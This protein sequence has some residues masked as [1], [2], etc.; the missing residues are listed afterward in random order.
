[1]ILEFS[2]E[3]YLSFKDKV[4]FSM[5]PDG[6]KKL[7]EN[8]VTLDNEKILK[9]AAVY[10]P[11]ASG[12]TNLFSMLSQIT[13]MLRQSNYVDINAPLP[14]VPFKFDNKIKNNPSSFEIKFIKNGIKYIYGFSADKKNIYEEY[15][16][17]YPNNKVA[18]IFDRTDI[19]TY[20]F[21][22]KSQTTLKEIQK[23]TPH[24]KFF[25]ATATNWNYQE[26]KPAYDFLTVDMGVCFSLTEL[27]FGA[28]K[29]YKNDKNERL[30]KFA[31]NFLNKADFNISDYQVNEVEIPKEIL[32]SV[33]LPESAKENPKAFQVS[34]SHKV[35]N[36]E[37]SLDIEEESIGTQ[38][39]FFLIP[40]ISDAIN[41]QKVLIIDE[42]DRSLH[43]LLV[44]YIVELFNNQS[45]ATPSQLIFNTHDTNLLNLEILRRDQIW[46]TEKEPNSS[47]SD[48]YSLND[49][50]VRNKEN[51]EKGYMLGKYGAIPFIEQNI[52]IWLDD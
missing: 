4:T 31:I 11:N 29:A 43:P 6:T 28:F 36:K 20:S 10:G 46:F 21:P 5:I 3:N 8:Y 48:L 23:K 33:N 9:T 12:K 27:R 15:L 44:K 51:V 32:V 39:L 7:A 38:I 34:I 35:G 25:L 26:T 52:N 30:K 24:N 49:F 42:L 22:Q 2:V 19:D 47:S 50:S 13:T 1:M 37:Y 14:L 18:K 41:N 45:S 40:F 16:Y 17:Y